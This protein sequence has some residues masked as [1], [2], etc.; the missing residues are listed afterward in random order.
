MARYDFNQLEPQSFT[1]LCNA[2]LHRVISERVTPGPLLGRDAGV[3][4]WYE[5]PGKGDWTDW[6][7][8]WIFQ[9]KF[10][11]VAR[12]GV[13]RCRRAVRSDVENEL[14][15]VFHKYHH[16]ADNYILITNVP[17]APTPGSAARRWLDDLAAKYVADGLRHIDLWDLDK[18][19]SLLDVHRDL[20]ERYFGSGLSGQDYPIAE[21]SLDAILED[22]AA[23][24]RQLAIHRR[25]LRTLQEKAAKYGPLDVP[26]FIL[27]QIDDEENA[28]RGL[29]QELTRLQAE[30]ERWGGG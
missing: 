8:A 9:Y 28:I 25:N 7:G 26:L 18:L 5:G 20:A 27:N 19:N 12:Q 22:I 15:K 16:R 30:R 4:A 3:D 24:E 17:Y 1:E 21:E 23:L 29:E 11:N 14:E 6:D 10:H 13:G 2:L